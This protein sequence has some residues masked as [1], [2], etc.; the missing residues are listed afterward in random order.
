M[1]KI[2]KICTNGR[3]ISAVVS[4]LGAIISAAF[5]GCRLCCGEVAVK[6]FNCEIFSQYNTITN[7]VNVK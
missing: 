2:L 5:A 3:V 4:A 1:T 6:D 7:G